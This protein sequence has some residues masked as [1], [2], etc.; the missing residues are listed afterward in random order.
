VCSSDLG[1]TEAWWVLD[2]TPGAFVWW[3]LR[4]P[5]S[6]EGLRNLLHRGSLSERLRRLPV[7]PGAVIVN[8]A[9]TIHALGAGVLAYEV[10]Q[11]SDLTYRLDDHG[12]LDG[13]GQPRALH[14][15]D[16]VAVAT[17]VPGEDVAPLPRVLGPGRSEIAR[18]HA[19][20]LERIEPWGREL[21]LTLSAG[22]FEIISNLGSESGEALGAGEDSLLIPAGS[23]WLFAAGSGSL[24]LRGGGPYARARYPS[25]T[26]QAGEG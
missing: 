21:P 17:L 12:R 11:A 16:G 14:L 13:A 1:K 26:P 19:F 8:P 5:I 20:V 6:R 9:G 22:S 24:R 23:S 4:E 18:T 2:A 15:E 25:R 7:A 10:Q 3:G